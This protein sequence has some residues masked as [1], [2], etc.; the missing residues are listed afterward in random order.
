VIDHLAPIEHPG[1]ALSIAPLNAEAAL[2]RNARGADR[3]LV[4]MLW[5]FL[6]S[7]GMFLANP[8]IGIVPVIGSVA[9][10]VAQQRKAKRYLRA[11]SL[12]GNGTTCTLDVEDVLLV[13]DGRKAMQLTLSP[14]VSQELR[15]K[16][17]PAAIVSLRDP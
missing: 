1:V 5:I 7:L 13:D 2:K 17:L 14:R 16:R 12:C 11:A 10:V 15:R 3:W 9:G 4:M 6:L 8:V